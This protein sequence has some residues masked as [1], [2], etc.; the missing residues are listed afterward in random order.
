MPIY[1]YNCPIHGIFEVI[2]QKV[3]DYIRPQ[4]FCEAD[5]DCTEPSDLQMSLC[6]MKPD[7]HWNGTVL[8]NGKLVTNSKEYNDATENWETISDSSLA[9]T[10][11]RK[12]RKQKETE[13]KINKEVGKFV[14][15]ELAG[16]SI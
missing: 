4:I 8:P 7:S 3:P 9:S 16:V 10:K 14:A 15:S 2:Y 6:T 5:D 13:D 1:E 12:L 11:Q